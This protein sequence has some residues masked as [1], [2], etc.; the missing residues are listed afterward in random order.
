MTDTAIVATNGAHE[1]APAS[2]L[3][4]AEQSRLDELEGKIDGGLEALWSIKEENLY[5][6]FGTFAEYME[7]RWGTSAR[8]GNQMVAAYKAILV[9]TEALKDSGTPVPTNESQVRPLITMTVQSPEQAVEIYRAAV[10]LAG[11]EAPKG[12][13]VMLS[14]RL[15]LTPDEV[16]REDALSQIRAMQHYPAL[17]EEA[18]TGNFVTLLGLAAAL[19]SCQP[20]VRDR[21]IMAN[22]RD[23]ALIR[24]LND[25]YVKGRDTAKEVL[26]TGAL[27]FGEDGDGIL[28]RNATSKDYRRLVTAA[29]QEH[30]AERRAQRIVGQAVSVVVF[31]D[32]LQGTVES[33]LEVLGYTVLTR[34]GALIGEM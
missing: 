6:A 23:L 29:Y 7:R 21:L 25:D 26:H 24:S 16:N 15:S 14:R 5:R 1:P 9:L 3:T 32:D 18:K 13:Q 34:L 30:L 27:Q 10:A 20:Y 33:L 2:A 17:V 11:G 31:P 22:V 8:R 28:L 4:T 12:D 19:E